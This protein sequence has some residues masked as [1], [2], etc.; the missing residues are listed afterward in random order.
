MQ[1]K[2]MTG[3]PTNFTKGWYVGTNNTA[4]AKQSLDD[5]KA[6]PFHRRGDHQELTI[7]VKPSQF[8]VAHTVY[9]FD[10][11]LERPFFYECPDRSGLRAV[12]TNQQQRCMFLYLFLLK[13]LVEGFER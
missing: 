5:G 2:I 10:T 6:K 9:Q 13:K 1:V 12:V 7:C 11:C 4:A 3:I 8:S